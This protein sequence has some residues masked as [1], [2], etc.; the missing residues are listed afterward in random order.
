MMVALVRDV[1]TDAPKA[2]HRT[3]LGPAGDKL[4][5]KCLGPVGGGA[6]KLTDSADVTLGLGIGE[7]IETTLSL[8]RLP[9]LGNLAVWSLLSAGQVER[10]PVLAGVEGLW[11]AVDHDPAGIRASEATAERWTAGGRDV[12]TIAPTTTGADLNDIGGGA[13]AA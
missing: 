6:V 5:R 3:Y 8:R 4:D 2:I 10:F 7:G 1:V 12:F 9:D 11:I 13:H